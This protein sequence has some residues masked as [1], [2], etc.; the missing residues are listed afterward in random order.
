MTWC[1]KKMESPAPRLISA[2]G[3]ISPSTW[4]VLELKWISVISR[5]RGASRQPDSLTRLRI[6]SG[7]PH[8]RQAVAVFSF[9]LW[10]HWH[11]MRSSGAPAGM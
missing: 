1:S 2:T 10:H 9:M 6:S 7:A 3:T 11:W 8:A 4:Q 5:M